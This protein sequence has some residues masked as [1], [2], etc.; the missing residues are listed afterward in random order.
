[1]KTPKES[2]TTKTLTVV[3]CVVMILSLAVFLAALT[4]MIGPNARNKS[5]GTVS[6]T[7]KTDATVQTEA[8]AVVTEPAPTASAEPALEFP[9]TAEKLVIESLFQFSGFNPDCDGQTGTDIAAIMVRNNSG[10][11]L[12]DAEL[13]LTMADNT[14]LTFHVTDLPADA[15]AMAFSKENKAI[16]VEAA[17]INVECSA[18]YES[19]SVMMEKLVTVSVNGTEITVTNISDQ[20]LTQVV[21]HCHCL[22]EED[23]FGGLTYQYIVDTLPAGESAVLEA[24]DCYMG[25]AEVVRVGI[26][27]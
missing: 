8:S 3:L 7:E 2:K 15:T 25:E 6:P 9:Y 11:H 22:L 5:D 19:A 21:V 10:S 26:G 13:T 18:S 12:A 27:S 16:K 23:Y 24:Y 14:I 17:C 4:Q 20:D 1:M